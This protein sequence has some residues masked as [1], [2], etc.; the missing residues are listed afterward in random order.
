MSTTVGA[1]TTVMGTTIVIRM[2]IGTEAFAR[3]GKR[4]KGVVEGGSAFRPAVS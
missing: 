2:T 1:I 4:K 3:L